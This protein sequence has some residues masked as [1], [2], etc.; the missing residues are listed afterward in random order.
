MSRSRSRLDLDRD[1][2]ELYGT[3]LRFSGSRLIY[4]RPYN[5]IFVYNKI[6]REIHIHV[7]AEE[8]YFHLSRVRNKRTTSFHKYSFSF[9]LELLSSLPY[10]GIGI[11]IGIPNDFFP[12]SGRVS[13]QRD[14][15]GTGSGPKKPVSQDSSEDLGDSIDGCC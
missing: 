11:V 15:I 12:G 5:N 9:S 8:P 1:G 4:S 2:F 3:G 7:Q 14:G 6:K 13:V 10:L